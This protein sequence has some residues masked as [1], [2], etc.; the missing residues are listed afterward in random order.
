MLGPEPKTKEDLVKQYRED[1]LTDAARKIIAAEGFNGVTVERV[2][3]MA[4]VSKGT[5]YLYFKNKEDLIRAAII[6]TF[7]TVIAQ[8]REATERE[9]D[10]DGRLR[11][12]VATQLRLFSENQAFF[13][14]LA[15]DHT[16][17]PKPGCGDDEIIGTH[18]MFVGFISEILSRGRLE[19]R[20]RADVP[21][22]EA[23]FFLVHLLQSTGFRHL[24][25][26]AQGDLGSESEVNRILSLVLNGIGAHKE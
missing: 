16:H 21:V 2:A 22:E 18:V 7:R 9:A 20:V 5:I 15:A 19:G 4:G 3:E 25:G 14:A 10:F 24:F 12:L 26:F 6:S 23:A 1:T 17:R 8:V 11:A 13:R